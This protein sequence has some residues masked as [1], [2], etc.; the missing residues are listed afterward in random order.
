[1]L[2]VVAP[3]E[4]GGPD[5]ARSGHVVQRMGIA[6]TLVGTDERGTLVPALA[7]GWRLSEDRL[8]W[9][10]TP[11]PEA[12]FHDGTPVTA[13][14]V[15]AA[16]RRARSGPGPLAQIPLA[17]IVAEA[18]E[19]VL[20]H[21]YTRRL[22]AA[23][24]AAWAPWPR[25]EP[26]GMLIEGPGL[27]KRFGAQRLFEGV[28]LALREGGRAALFGPSGS[29]KSTLGNRLLGLPRPDAG[30]VR[31]APGLG[32]PFVQKLYQ[33]PVA[34]FAP[35]RMV[36]HAIDAVVAR[37]R[38]D[39]RLPGRW[40]QAL[41]LSPGLLTRQPDEVSGGELQRFALLRTML[42]DPRVLFADEP[43]SRL[44]PVT[45]QKVMDRLRD[46]KG[47]ALPLPARLG[48][49]APGVRA[50]RAWL[51][52]RAADPK[53][54][55]SGLQRAAPPRAGA[56][57]GQA[58]GGPALAIQLQPRGLGHRPKP[59]RAGHRRSGGGP[60]G[61]GPGRGWRWPCQAAGAPAQGIVPACRDRS[62]LR[63]AASH[64]D[65]PEQGIGDVAMT[66]ELT[67]N[68]RPAALPPGWEE[69]SLLS[70]LRFHLRLAGVRFGCGAGLCGACTVLVDGQ[71]ERARALP[72]AAAI[73]R[74]ITTAEGFS[75]A[76]GAPAAVLRAW[77]ELAVPQCGYCQPG[78]MAQA[79][80]VLAARP[81]PAPEAVEAALAGVLCRCGTAPRIRA[82]VSRA[83]SILA[84][85]S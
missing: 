11:R 27:A 63:H 9:R 67:V 26:G 23:E 8:T 55:P 51:R 6:E 77:E 54:R 66:G 17:S 60:G 35:R 18:D 33:D 49:P 37:H 42:P 40:M 5:R 84:G 32:A 65:V 7:R 58:A 69:E 29:G 82:A 43:T 2:R 85:E 1:V 70:F 74:R 28:S 3:W 73:G 30:E 72:A 46:A 21:A 20:R 52:R 75:A 76:G 31:R 78:Q 45:Q 71:A 57:P 56:A 19:V 80:A 34:A 79:A 10:V 14:A 13:E 68:G 25:A 16:L 38:L 81:R 4:I 22:L 83:A 53:G 12:T 50:G 36:G 61:A 41:R 62:R 44:D 24:P 59:P 48:D 64:I 39:P 47:V 15:A